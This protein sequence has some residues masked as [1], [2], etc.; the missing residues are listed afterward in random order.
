VPAE[1]DNHF[2]FSCE[3][4]DTG[5]GIP[6]DK[7]PLLFGEF[8]QVDASTTRKYGGTGLGLSITKKLCNLL[9]GDVSI[10]S[11]VGVGSC[12]EINLLVEQSELSTMVVPSIDS[13]KLKVLIV[14]DNKTNREVLRGQLECW[15]VTVTEA[16]SGEEAL[17]L[18]NKYFS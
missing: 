18:C 11:E 10:T 14:D 16:K 9:N 13:S 12:F 2:I 4:Q 6:E 8:S 5:I 7:I 1:K 15:G 17:T 3:I